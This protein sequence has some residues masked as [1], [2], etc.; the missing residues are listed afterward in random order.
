[1]LLSLLI[2]KAGLT[3]EV[4]TSGWQVGGC[5]VPSFTMT[6]LDGTPAL[7]SNGCLATAS[8]TMSDTNIHLVFTPE[9]V[10]KVDVWLG[11][12]ESVFSNNANVK[13]GETIAEVGLNEP[14]I[15]DSRVSSFSLGSGQ[16][17]SNAED[18]YAVLVFN[19]YSSSTGGVS[20]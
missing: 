13:L 7:D 9:D 12:G 14:Q 2:T 3:T 20:A 17:T 5:A 15:F 11:R 6:T 19:C 10:P 4:N 1:M 18:T 16:G 8:T